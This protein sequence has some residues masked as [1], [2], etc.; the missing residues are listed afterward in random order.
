MQNKKQY[1]LIIYWKP[2]KYIK[3]QIQ[4]HLLLYS[5]FILHFL[6][7]YFIAF[8]STASNFQTLEF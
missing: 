4:L 2:L 5:Y 8:C 1:S 3:N 7:F 6:K